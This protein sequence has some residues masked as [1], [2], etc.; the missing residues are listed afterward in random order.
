MLS[1]DLSLN[2]NQN[3]GQKEPK[4]ISTYILKKNLDAIIMYKDKS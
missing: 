1:W 4:I 3:F 2:E